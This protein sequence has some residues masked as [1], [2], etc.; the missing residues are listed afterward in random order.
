MYILLCMD[1]YV[2]RWFDFATVFNFLVYWV[3]V[4]LGLLLY[5]SNTSLDVNYLKIIVFWITWE[6]LWN[7]YMHK[8]ENAPSKTVSPHCEAQNQLLLPL[9]YSWLSRYKWIQRAWL[10]NNRRHLLFLPRPF[11]LWFSRG[12]CRYK[13]DKHNFIMIFH[14]VVLRF[15]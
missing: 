1:N 13:V 15:W 12:I 5:C 11:T 3:K 6:L 7:M 9:F 14:K 8:D 2:W 10:S 4:T